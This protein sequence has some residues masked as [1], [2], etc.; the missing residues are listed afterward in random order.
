MH[1]SP[2]TRSTN[3]SSHSS[4]LIHLGSRTIRVIPPPPPLVSKSD[5]FGT[6]LG[7]NFEIIKIRVG[8]DFYFYSWKF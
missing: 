1:G 7:E 2:G 6:L 4:S 5:T 3:F 8:E